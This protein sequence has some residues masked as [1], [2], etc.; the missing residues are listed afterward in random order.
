MNDL[1]SEKAQCVDTTRV[2]LEPFKQWNHIAAII[3]YVKG[4]G[5]DLI[6]ISGGETSPRLQRL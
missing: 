1:K 6:L 2:C 3:A 4:E 5:C